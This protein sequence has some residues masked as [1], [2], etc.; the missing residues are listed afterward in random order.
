VTSPSSEP[1]KRRTINPLQAAAVLAVTVLL[2]RVVGF[3]QANI[4]MRLLPTAD[5]EAYVAAFRIPNVVNYLVAGGAISITFI[6]VFTALEHAGERREAWKFFST[7]VTI[8]AVIL[9]ALT[10]LGVIFAE[11]LVRL[12]TPG[13]NDPKKAD[14]LALTVTMTR[15]LLPAQVFFYI[16]GL[17]VGVLNSHKR[18]GA[19]GMTGTIYNLVAIFV[20]LTLWFF[21]GSPGFVWGIFIGAF[22]G[23]FLLPLIAAHSGPDEERI[24]FSI[25]F[26]FRNP[27]VKRYFR[28]ALPI[29]LGVSLPVV[30]QLVVGAFASYL[31]IGA[32]THLEN[33]NRVMLAP[34]GVLAQA[35]SV[36]AFPFMASDSAAQN[37]GALADFLRTGLRR[38]MFLA[39]PISMVLILNARPIIDLLYGYGEYLN[40]PKAVPQT[41]VAFAFYC[42]GLFAWAGQQ[43]VARGFYALQDTV[44]PTV[45]G[46]ILAIFFFVPL[47]WIAGRWGGVMGLALA[48]SIGATAHFCGILI[49]FESK[50]R[51][52]PYGVNLH[53]ERV[54]GTLLRTV[55]ATAIMGVV[56]IV[57]LRFFQPN[58]G[59]LAD[60]KQIFVVSVFSSIAFML[61]AQAFKIPEWTWVSGKF[62]S[63]LKRK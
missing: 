9:T 10:I 27:A 3:V 37:W 38:L 40:N 59:K 7:I 50:L 60:L 49:Y 54:L 18:F 36:A 57:I 24:H 35:A 56:G 46:S 39:L 44:T 63:R 41:S 43:F 25:S 26:D 1:T 28:N 15:V 11:P 16:G 20:G 58:S 33:G 8:M 13:F 17:I 6:P 61:A 23:N 48:T 14:V 47:C 19:S 51:R 62:L 30:D 12:I 5:A 4:I 53:S 21:L 34:L 2:S 45:I 32:L 42:V 31:P 29:M 55:C 52:R 22:A